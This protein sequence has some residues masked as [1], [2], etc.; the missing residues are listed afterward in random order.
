VS[1]IYN[2]QP[3]LV[4]EYFRAKN[5]DHIPYLSNKQ[6]D[7]HYRSMERAQSALE[8]MNMSNGERNKMLRMKRFKEADRQE[9]KRQAQPTSPQPLP[10]P[11]VPPENI[12]FNSDA[13]PQPVSQASAPF[14]M[15]FANPK[16][17]QLPFKASEL[18]ESRADSRET[19]PE[20]KP[21]DANPWLN[22]LKQKEKEKTTS[23]NDFF[24]EIRVTTK[25]Q[26]KMEVNKE[27]ESKLATFS[28]IYL[29]SSISMYVDLEDF[30]TEF[31]DT[32]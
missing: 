17:F 18:K 9:A 28:Q 15:P 6:K 29:Q 20:S 12:R 7:D 16:A 1:W 2:D 30:E 26:E 14:K 24:K 5:I 13:K 23:V 11:F 25:A 27:P 10:I 8:K 21:E 3:D 22:D 31:V 4:K 19:K 32:V